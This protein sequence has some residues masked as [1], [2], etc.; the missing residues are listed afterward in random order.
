MSYADNFSREVEVVDM[1]EAQELVV[2]IVM[3]EGELRFRDALIASLESELASLEITRG[4][5]NWVDGVRY[6]IHLV[7]NGDFGVNERGA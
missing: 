4:N 5:Q 2:K 6:C 1:T 7:R 3:K